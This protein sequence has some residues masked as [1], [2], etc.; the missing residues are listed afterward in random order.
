MNKINKFKKNIMKVFKFILLLYIVIY[1]LL[2]ITV[3]IF[4]PVNY[5]FK[6][7]ITN[8]SNNVVTLSVIDND[9][10]EEKINLNIWE[11]YNLKRIS[12][13]SDNPNF[14][15]YNSFDILIG[16][17]KIFESINYWTPNYKLN[18]NINISVNK[19]I[20]KKIRYL[21]TYNKEEFLNFDYTL[22][23]NKK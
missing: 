5:I 7:K 20:Y 10:K 13:I 19:D 6:Y 18:N 21:P 2:C 22:I 14:S 15:W 4:H 23:I 16:N 11:E 17:E 3:Y 1:L 12:I 8:N 9:F